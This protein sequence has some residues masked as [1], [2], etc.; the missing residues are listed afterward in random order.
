LLPAQQTPEEMLRGLLVLTPCEGQQQDSLSTILS[1]DPSSNTVSGLTDTAAGPSRQAVGACTLGWKSVSA[2]VCQPCRAVQP[3]NSNLHC[4]SA[5][6][7]PH[8]PTSSSSSTSSNCFGCRPS[9]SHVPQATAH[10]SFSKRR[11]SL[12]HLAL[13]T[14]PTPLYLGL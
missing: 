14:P 6:H 13:C 11:H 12:Y 8:N 5:H 10:D 3:C 4:M 7:P 9:A 2:M 1:C